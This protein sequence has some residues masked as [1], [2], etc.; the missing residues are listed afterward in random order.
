MVNKV[1]LSFP[2]TEKYVAR[3]SAI[4]LFDSSWKEHLQKRKR[5][6]KCSNLYFWKSIGGAKAW[7]KRFWK[8]R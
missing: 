7:M 3:V 8:M 1:N 5:N 6:K 2:S 4:I